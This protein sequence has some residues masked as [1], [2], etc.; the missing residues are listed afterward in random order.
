MNETDLKPHIPDAKLRL[1]CLNDK[2]Q[3]DMLRVMTVAQWQVVV[4]ALR[5]VI[6]AEY[7][8][9]RLVIKRGKVR[10]VVPATTIELKDG[11]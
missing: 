8:E 4:N 11:E 6:G 3:I 2:L 7:G 10:F 1:A 5:F 9:V